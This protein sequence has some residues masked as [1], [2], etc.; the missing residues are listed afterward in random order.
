[1]DILLAVFLGGAL[2]SVLRFIISQKIN[3]LW[4]AHFPCGIL[5]VNVSGCLLVGLLRDD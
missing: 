3:Q 4:G 5:L 1:M 2:G